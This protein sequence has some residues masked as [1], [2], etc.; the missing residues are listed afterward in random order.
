MSHRGQTSWAIM[1]SLRGKLIAP[2]CHPTKFVN[3]AE[4]QTF[5][6]TD[7]GHNEHDI[8]I[9]WWVWIL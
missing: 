7:I 9:S 4:E 8:A 1:M 5:L 6:T 3:K 2:A